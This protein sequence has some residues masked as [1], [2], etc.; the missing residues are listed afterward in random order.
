MG[1]ESDWYDSDHTI[2]RQIIEGEFTVDEVIKLRER[3]R[4]LFTSVSY[5]V[6]LLTIVKGTFHLPRDFMRALR[7]NQLQA[8]QNEGL[9]II[10][11]GGQLARSVYKIA[12]AV[13]PG[14]TLRFSFAGSV[15]E[16]LTLIAEQKSK[17]TS[18]KPQIE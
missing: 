13:N 6:Y 11:G 18:I 3:N 2:I 4:L 17:Q 16:A 9:H 15:E 10:V 8:E 5:P 7:T 12:K 1:L 14:M